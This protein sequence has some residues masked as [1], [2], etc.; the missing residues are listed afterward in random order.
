[1]A[2]PDGVPG[3][4]KP[5]YYAARAGGWRDWW[6]LLHPP[7]TAWHLSYVVIGACL[8]PQVRVDRLVAT[9][10]AFLLAVGLAAHALDELNGRPLGTRISSRWLVT[11]AGLGIGAAV[12]LG[13]VGVARVGWTLV[14]F[15]VV[16]PVLVVTYNLNFKP[17]HKDVAFAAAWGAF[18]VLT[19]YVA[20]TQQIAWPAVLAAAAAFA[21]S[22]AQRSL[23]TP[24]RL[25]RR[26]S[27]EA[28]GSITLADGSQRPIDRR[29]LLDPLERALNA[30][31]ASV[32]LLATALAL[33]R[34]T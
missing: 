2:D 15:I 7:Y 17:I 28:S 22:T 26:R 9:V 25:L 8:A 5:A 24:A 1:M 3:T 4:L 11:T 31:A 32:V 16:G 27:L 29:T 18:P 23:S 12:A 20:E 13:A 34:L 30:S 14:P 19:A 33:A 21:L 10:L 6:T